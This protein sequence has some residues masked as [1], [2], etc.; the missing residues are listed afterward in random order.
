MLI[1]PVG[2]EPL[3]GFSPLVGRRRAAAVHVLAPPPT[4][5]GLGFAELIS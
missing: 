2:L 1:H 4:L 3:Q 5:R